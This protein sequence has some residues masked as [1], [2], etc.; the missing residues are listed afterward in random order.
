[1][2]TEIG[3]G[4][5]AFPATSWTL[6]ERARK[7]PAGVEELARLYWKPVYCFLRQAGL[8]G[9]EDAK[10]LAQEFF[11]RIVLDGSLL[12]RYEPGRG[13]FRPYLKT[14]LRNFLAQARR[15]GGAQKR[16]G[17]VTIVPLEDALPD[18]QALGPEEAFDKAWERTILARALEGLEA[19]LRRED[20][21]LYWEIFRSYELGEAPTYGELGARLGIGADAVKNHLTHARK[22]FVDAAKEVLSREVDGPGELSRELDAL[23]G[24]A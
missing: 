8:K 16:G 20:K 5:R 21:A 2:E 4:E 19:R 12:G 17:Q 22:A 11:A 18:V 9:N 23:F 14:A 15:D 3:G 6:L 1:M 7:E 10:D 13:G 24:G